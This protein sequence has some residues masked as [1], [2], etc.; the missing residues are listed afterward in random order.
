MMNA[1]LR[2]RA[3]N[4]R[5]DRS[6]PT[7][8]SL[9]VGLLCGLVGLSGIGP[10]AVR[11][12]GAAASEA[13]PPA[14][15]PAATNPTG[16]TPGSDATGSATA[17]D[18]AARAEEA[19][20]QRLWQTYWRQVAARF[21]SLEGRFICAPGY[22][23]RFASSAKLTPAQVS[24][25]N[26]RPA[27][28]VGIR[29]RGTLSPPPVDCNAGAMLLPRF[30]IG[31]YGYIDSANVEAVL[32][33]DD[34]IVS[35]IWLLNPDVI[36]RQREEEG[37][38][39]RG[40]Y[41]LARKYLDWAFTERS[42]AL[43]RQREY[44]GLRLRIKGY[45]TNGVVTGIRWQGP[46][47]GKGIQ[48]AIVGTTAFGDASEDVSSVVYHRRLGPDGQTMIVREVVS[49]PAQRRI[50]VAVPV[51]QLGKG[52][53]E[54][55]FKRLLDQRGMTV[56]GFVDRMLEELKNNRGEAID[57][58]VQ[59]IAGQADIADAGLVAPDRPSRPRP[60]FEDPNAPRPVTP[61]QPKPTDPKPTVEP[62][63]P[64]PPE[65]PA[66]P[67]KPTPPTKPESPPQPAPSQSGSG[68]QPSPPP[69]DDK[70][71]RGLF[72]F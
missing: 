56:K 18:Y 36:D 63:P 11:A 9:V 53:D 44:S 21:A 43:D 25:A 26:T 32:G 30:G 27:V 10:A 68:D 39:L 31:E 24:A 3:R 19:R 58:M 2:E 55:S 45:P 29:Q 37:K 17:I 48:V 46:E 61:T 22:D 8:G 52:L 49:R 12:Q 59:A 54:E 38:P 69:S 28:D 41:F 66:D 23:P 42:K 72:D 67:A 50:F 5:A 60:L 7:R 57:R 13:S 35:D 40:D 62:K 70:P 47:P 34:M 64:T 20:V 16:E 71:R 1:R 15:P 51:K 14:T 65:S 33:P 6:P 4:R